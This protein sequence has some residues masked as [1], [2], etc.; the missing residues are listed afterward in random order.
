MAT[1]CVRLISRALRNAAAPLV[2]RCA[3]TLDRW[4]CHALGRIQLDGLSQR[5]KDAVS[6][7]HLMNAA[8]RG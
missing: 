4:V 7:A 1:S 5:S 8:M 3:S 2:N 6:V